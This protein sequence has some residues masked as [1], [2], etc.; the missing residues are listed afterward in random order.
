MQR[1]NKQT[2][3]WV[4]LGGF[5]GEAS[6]DGAGMQ[7][8]QPRGERQVRACHPKVLRKK[9]GI[10][11][12]LSHRDLEERSDHDHS[13]MITVSITWITPFEVSMSAV[14]T[15]A[16]FTVTPPSVMMVRSP[17]CTVVAIMLLVRSVD[18]TLPG[19]T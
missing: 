4:L 6:G 5:G 15:V 3:R 9:A 7:R 1:V 10:A 12:R 13:G 2:A 8:Q 18:M 17:P 11:A 14:V 16:P 19:T